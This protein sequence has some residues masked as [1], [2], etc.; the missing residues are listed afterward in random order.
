MNI[1]A[2]TEEE[3]S[4]ALKVSPYEEGFVNRQI[5]KLFSTAEEVKLRPYILLLLAGHIVTNV[6]LQSEGET[7]VDTALTLVEISAK[8]QL[9]N[10]SK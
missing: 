2:K 10:K 4:E 5:A 6:V 9:D 3:I 7:K 1:R 8:S